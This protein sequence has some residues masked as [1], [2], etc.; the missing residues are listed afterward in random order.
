MVEAAAGIRT[1]WVAV[2]GEHNERTR[3]L[4]AA[5]EARRWGA[6]GSRSWRRSPGST[7][8]RFAAVYFVK[9]FSPVSS[10]KIPH[11]PWCAY[12]EFPGGVE[13]AWRPVTGAGTATRRAPASPSG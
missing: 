2:S 12:G 10:R 4:E 9:G 7:G 11:R 1:R 3:R 8:R 6:A 5:A 13:S